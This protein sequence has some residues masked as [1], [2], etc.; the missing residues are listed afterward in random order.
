VDDFR[1]GGR[2]FEKR[3]STA[4]SSHLVVYGLMKLSC[5]SLPDSGIFS[6][7]ELGG[8]VSDPLVGNHT[9]KMPESLNRLNTGESVG[10]PFVLLRCL[11]GM[12]KLAQL[13][14]GRGV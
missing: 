7:K 9:K 10:C 12:A 1:A 11:T 13:G 2:C 14:A 4:H 6:A 8:Q 5:D 3:G